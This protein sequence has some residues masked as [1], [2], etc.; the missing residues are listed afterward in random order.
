MLTKLIAE[1]QA[2]SDSHSKQQ[3][4]PMKYSVVISPAGGTIERNGDFI[5]LVDS[6]ATA[7][8]WLQRMK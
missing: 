8:K 3:G 4:Y 5:K 7:I 1:L 2:I 6:L